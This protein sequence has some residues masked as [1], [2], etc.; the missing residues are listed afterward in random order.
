MI[1]QADIAMDSNHDGDAVSRPLVSR[2]LARVLAAVAMLGAFSTVEA[3]AVRYSWFEVSYVRQDVAKDGSF[4]DAGINQT[5]NVSSSDGDGIEFRGSVGTWHN[6]FAFLDFNSS[7]IDVAATVINDQGEFSAVDEFD[8]TAIR[9]GLGI[10]WS[11]TNATDLYAAASYDSTD[12]D[13]GSFAGENF[14][15]SDQGPG[16]SVGVRS[17]FGDRL[18]LRAYARY[19][20]VG[21][22]DLTTRQA[23]GDTL[24]GVGFGIELVRGLSI[25]GD[26][27]DGVFS[28]WNVGFRLDLDED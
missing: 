9:G 7:D 24:Y 11:M 3:Q 2:P 8:F 18:E 19:S 25:V 12:L 1:K 27:E 22:L 21:D 17:I 13:F 15:V 4:T 26:Y 6:F 16:G 23:D 14:D 28:S 5:V 20:Q 10:K